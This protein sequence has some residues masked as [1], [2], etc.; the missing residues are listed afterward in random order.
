MKGSTSGAS[1]N[2]EGTIAKL[3][4]ITSYPRNFL[5][6]VCPEADSTLLRCA[7]LSR[8]VHDHHVFRAQC[9]QCEEFGL[10]KAQDPCFVP[11]SSLN[12]VPMGWCSK[13]DH[14]LSPCAPFWRLH[15]HDHALIAR[16][17]LAVI[18]VGRAA[19]VWFRGRVLNHQV[20][21]IA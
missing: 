19:A 12:C 2:G 15:P 6:N 1:P 16:P 5:C 14:M 18:P 20:S 9:P 21:N 10:R 3:P 11:C 4:N 17:R 7:V 8:I 13:C